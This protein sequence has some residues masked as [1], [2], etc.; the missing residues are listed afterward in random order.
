[1]LQRNQEHFLLTQTNFSTGFQSDMLL[2]LSWK[3]T[4]GKLQP[5]RQPMGSTASSVGQVLVELLS[6]KGHI[7][8]SLFCHTEIFSVSEQIYCW[9]AREKLLLF[10]FIRERVVSMWGFWVH[11]EAEVA[12]HGTPRVLMH[13]QRCT[14]NLKMFMCLQ[15]Q[16]STRAH[17]LREESI[18]MF[19]FLGRAYCSFHVL[20][21]RSTASLCSGVLWS[22]LCTYLHPIEK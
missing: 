10:L 14:Q 15:V 9:A 13:D 20:S 22:C 7:R 11:A 1:M 6:P 21:A 5:F 17:V 4:E 2:F 12:F 3:I 16:R 8:I 18:K 19:C